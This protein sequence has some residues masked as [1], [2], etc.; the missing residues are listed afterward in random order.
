LADIANTKPVSRQPQ[1]R[2]QYMGRDF[3]KTFNMQAVETAGLPRPIKLW[4]PDKTQ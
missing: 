3:I 1:I 4:Q 2:I